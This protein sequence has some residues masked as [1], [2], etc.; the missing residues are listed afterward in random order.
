M[1][2]AELLRHIEPTHEAWWSPHVWDGDRRL[3][4]NWLA[5]S[6]LVVDVDYHDADGKHAAPASEVRARLRQ[7]AHEGEL[8]GNVFHCTPRGARFIYVTAEP[9]ADPESYTRAIEGACLKTRRALEALGL[10]A[11]QDERGRFLEGYAVD[12]AATDL[13]RFLYAPRA[14]VNEE[15]RDA[16][17]HVIREELC[18]AEGLAA[19][20]PPP[21]PMQRPATGHDPR[22]STNLTEAVKRWN[23]DHA[24]DWGRPGAGE[25]R[26]CRH[27]GCFGRLP[28][29]PEKWC[30]FSS[31]H[32][33][34]SGGVGCS[35][36][37]GHWIGDALDLEAQR[38]NRKRV[39]VLRENGYLRGAKPRNRES[40]K[41]DTG[42]AARATTRNGVDGGEREPRGP[43]EKPTPGTLKSGVVGGNSTE[44]A[45]LEKPNPTDVG[46]AERLAA[47]YGGELRYCHPWRAWLVWDGRRW[48][49]DRS[50]EAWRRAKE[51]V[52]AMYHEAADLEDDAK[53]IELARHARSSESQRR[54]AGMLELAKSDPRIAVLPESFDG[55]G[56]RYL[57][58]VLN[59]TLDLRTGELRPHRPEDMITKLAPVE[60]HTEAKCPAWD[61]FLARVVPDP[62]VR[63]FLQRFLGY[64][65]TGHVGEQAFVL[66]YG[67]GANGKSTFLET[68]KALLGDYAH[69]ADF[70]TF[71]E[72]KGSRDRQGRAR[73]DLLALRGKRLVLAVEAGQERRLDAN[74][75]KEVTHGDSVSA[76]GLYEGEVTNFPPESKL[77]LAVNHRPEIADMTEAIWRSVLEVPFTVMIP[78]QERDRNLLE[79]LCEPGELAGILAGAVQGCMEWLRTGLRPPEAVQ[80]ATRAYRESEDAIAPFLAERCVRKAGSFTSHRVLFAAYEAWCTD[81]EEEPV[82]ARAFGRALVDHG[83]H[84][85]RGK[86]KARPKGWGGI[87]LREVQDMF[88]GEASADSSDPSD[89]VS[90]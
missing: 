11:R 21:A 43:R 14:I 26:A 67:T 54:I 68:L 5:A 90:T 16:D 60:Y 41:Q 4:E 79:K 49:R 15:Q 3:S 28:S 24:E 37:K 32:E 45:Q 30:C 23:A 74:L 61:A 73:P 36:T 64:T 46:N 22:S 66:L 50:G 1:A 20:L 82:G 56:T 55:D 18:S 44:P 42:A 52:R 25:C 12:A 72:S 8:P 40:G 89:P 17:V 51:T 29:I 88:D 35:S 70:E 62:E 7:A 85:A 80:L 34:D 65:L 27:R 10:H 84:R 83:F 77:F 39:D 69:K 33:A 9:M 53:R 19:E 81:A 87:R 47:Q 71:L 75:V 63:A 59:G 2:L 6:A 58:N 13:A 31:N 86:D 48:A 76:R 57:L 78:E 38:S